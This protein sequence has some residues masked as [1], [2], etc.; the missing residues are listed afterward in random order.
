MCHVAPERVLVRDKLW[1]HAAG[2]SGWLCV[3]SCANGDGRGCSPAS[4]RAV[5]PCC[6]EPPCTCIA[7]KHTGDE[8]VRCAGT[9]WV[10]V[11]WWAA[12]PGWARLAS[13][14]SSSAI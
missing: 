3:A 10:G 7:C 14:L 5:V 4:I 12:R 13:P 2:S 9:R 1:I 8:T 11:G 6:P